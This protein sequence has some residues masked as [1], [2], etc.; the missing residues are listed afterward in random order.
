MLVK[1]NDVVISTEAIRNVINFACVSLCVTEKCKCSLQDG[2]RKK[3]SGL[4]KDTCATLILKVGMQCKN[5]CLY[6]TIRATARHN[7]VPIGARGVEVRFRCGPTHT[8]FSQ[9]MRV[10]ILC[11]TQQNRFFC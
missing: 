3:I 11:E 8:F 2:A 7:I 4:A 9:E 6:E 10:F 1:H 5:M